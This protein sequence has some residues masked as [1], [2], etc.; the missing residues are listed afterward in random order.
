VTTLDDYGR[1]IAALEHLKHPFDRKQIG[2]I[3]ASKG[4]PAL[5]YVGHAIVTARLNQYAPDWSYTVDETFTHGGEF[6]IRG[7]MTICG[8]SRVEYGSG[9][10]PLQAISHFIRRAAMRFG[11][12]AE[13]WSKE[14]LETSGGSPTA[15]NAGTVG[16]AAP[17]PSSPGPQQ[18]TPSTAAGG[19]TSG[20]E[21]YGEGS[22]GP[23]NVEG[24]APAPAGGVS[25][26][27]RGSVASPSHEARALLVQL[28]GS[29]AKA[30]AWLNKANRSGYT[31]KTEGAATTEE[32]SAALDEF[33]KAS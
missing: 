8:V 32:W 30:R 6:W 17:A 26:D 28:A 23:A 10:D 1:L 2:K 16:H 24:E 31:A 33:E 27:N 29:E 15:P 25:G 5:D 19:S 12:A 4:R 18:R 13:L 21:G 3:P 20:P 11:V 22:D 7:T 9:P 14:E